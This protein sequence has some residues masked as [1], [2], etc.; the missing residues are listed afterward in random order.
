MGTLNF[1]G[2]KKLTV[3]IPPASCRRNITTRPQRN[4]DHGVR[5]ETD[6]LD[7]YGTY[8]VYFDD[9]RAV[10]DLFGESKRDSDDMSDGW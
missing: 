10:T 2:W 5:V 6:P 3:A 9:M 7:S 4:P 1:I 8:Y